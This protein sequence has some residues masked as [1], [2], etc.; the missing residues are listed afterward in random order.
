MVMEELSSVSSTSKTL[1]KKFVVKIDDVIVFKKNSRP[2]Y[3]TNYNVIDF[4]T[5]LNHPNFVRTRETVIF[6]YGAGQS[7]ATP[8]VH[9]VITAYASRQQFNFIVIVYED[10]A[11]IGTDVSLSKFCN[12]N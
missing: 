3:V 10:V 1:I 9:D 12:F 4:H 6:H 2:T 5:I 7:V 11:T 8:Q